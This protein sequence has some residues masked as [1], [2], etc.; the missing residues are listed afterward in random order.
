MGRASILEGKGRSQTR[1]R[2]GWEEK[3]EMVSTSACGE[4]RKEEREKDF[5]RKVG[6][7]KK[8]SGLDYKTR[9]QQNGEERREIRNGQS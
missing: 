2:R 6:K 8:H 1:Q 3:E 9:K 4:G 5:F 7:G